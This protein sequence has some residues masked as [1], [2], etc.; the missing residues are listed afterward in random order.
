MKRIAY[1][2][3]G[4]KPWEFWRL[5]HAEL[6]DMMEGRKHQADMEMRRLAWHAANVMNVH[7]KKPVTVEKL[8]KPKPQQTDQDKKK[9]FDKLAK[10]SDRILKKKGGVANG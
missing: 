3:L 6:L 1:G 8:L 4:L 9:Q 2:P 5:T 7:L 10:L